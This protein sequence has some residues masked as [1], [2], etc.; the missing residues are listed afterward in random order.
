MEEYIAATR[1]TDRVLDAHDR[2]IDDRCSDIRL[3]G[4]ELVRRQA[5]FANKSGTTNQGSDV[6]K[7]NA[8]GT[9]LT[10]RRDTLTVIKQSRLEIIF[11]GRWEMKHLCDANGNMFFDIDSFY[12]KVLQICH[13]F[14]KTTK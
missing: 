11:S 13:L 14:S 10:T 8:G 3:K 4:E 5:K 12:S 2:M 1:N 6:I 7:I 9:I